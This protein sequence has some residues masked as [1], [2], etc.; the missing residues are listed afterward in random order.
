M[1]ATLKAWGKEIPVTLVVMKYAQH[2]NTAIVVYD[3]SE[4]YPQAYCNLTV[5]LCHL[6]DG[7]LAF[8]DVNNCP[9]AE[10]FITNLGI[11]I[12]TG[13]ERKSGF[14]TY[15]LYLFNLDEV[16]KYSEV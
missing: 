5:N 6:T 8:V 11:A 12:P 4:G 13:V 3:H 14:V 15:P 1:V 16:R 7:D 2:G 10:E 9:W